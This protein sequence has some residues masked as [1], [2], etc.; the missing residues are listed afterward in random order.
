MWSQFTCPHCGSLTAVPAQSADQQAFCSACGNKV[1]LPPSDRSPDFGPPARSAGMPA[2]AIILIIA[3]FVVPLVMVLLVAVVFVLIPM[4]VVKQHQGALTS[5]A[6]VHL[7]MF[8]SAAEMY[9]LDLGDYPTTEQGLD[10]LLRPPA[11][12][13]DANSWRGPY[14]D[15]DVIPLDPWGQPYQY[16]Y[17]GQRDTNRPDIWSL[18][19]DAVADTADDIVSWTER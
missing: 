15:G 9:R 10:A 12:L 13:P 8:Q 7:A 18:G 16:E 19:P 17:P 4:R 3:F 1:P 6:E 11:D 2:W 5:E 14:V